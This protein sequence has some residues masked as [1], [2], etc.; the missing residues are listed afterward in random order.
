M[1]LE[2]TPKELH[3]IVILELSGRLVLGQESMDFRAKIKEV[4]EQ[5]AWTKEKWGWETRIVLDLGKVD[6]IDSSGLGAMIAAYT[7]AR[8][9]GAEIKL[10]NLTHRIKDLLNITKLAT[11]FEVYESVE[12]AVESFPKSSAAAEAA[13][14]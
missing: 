8:K 11:V 14:A 1:A 7:S 10:S 6:L 5:S 9:C 3:G 12:A 2:I 4:L 13:P